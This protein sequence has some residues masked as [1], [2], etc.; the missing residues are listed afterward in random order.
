M[1]LALIVGGLVFYQQASM[2]ARVNRVTSTASSLISETRALAVQNGSWSPLPGIL[3]T[4]LIA[5]GS[6]PQSALDETKPLGQRIRHPWDS[7]MMVSIQDYGAITY[8]NFSLWS[9][10]VAVCTRLAWFDGR[11]TGAFASNITRA[12]HA[13]SGL[14]PAAMK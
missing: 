10:P 4:V 13:Q 6:V 1:A 5:Q 8:L 2:A 3:E 7:N 14:Y 12:C 11:G 9:V